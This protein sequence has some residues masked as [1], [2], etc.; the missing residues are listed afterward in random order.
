MSVFLVSMTLSTLSQGTL[1]DSYAKLVAQVLLFMALSTV[2]LQGNEHFYLKWCLYSGRH[3]VRGDRDSFLRCQRARPPVARHDRIFNTEFD[4]NYIG[5]AF[6]GSTAL[7]LDNIL[8]NNKRLICILLYG[9]NVVAIP[10][11]GVRAGPCC[12]LRCQI[13][14]CF[15]SS[16]PGRKADDPENR[17]IIADGRRLCRRFIELCF[18]ELCRPVDAHLQRRAG[19]Q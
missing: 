6:V 16:L 8:R 18:S 11:F 3:G 9:I 13:W 10:L 19:R 2:K 1:P 5:I 17:Q 12:P 7:I 4:P 14:R 15:C